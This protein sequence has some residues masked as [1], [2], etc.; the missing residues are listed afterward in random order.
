MAN[1]FQKSYYWLT[2]QKTTAKRS[3][4]VALRSNSSFS[5]SSDI[6]RLEQVFGI[7]LSGVSVN[8]HTALT[9]P[10]VLRCLEIR[11]D[12]PASMPLRV[13]STTASGPKLETGHPLDY[14]L[15]IRPNDGQ[16]PFIFRKT[17]G[18]H[19]DIWGV[20]VAVVNRDEYRNTK[21]F[22]ILQRGEYQIYETLDTPM[23]K[24]KRTYIENDGTAHNEE[25][26]IIWGGISTDGFH[27][28]GIVGCAT[29]VI[30][31]GLT[32]RQFINKYYE[33]G[34]FL[35][36]I[37]TSENNMSKDVAEQNKTNWQSAH[38]GSGQAGKVAVLSGG[39]KFQ[40]ITN[41]L[42]DSQLVEFLSLDKHEIYQAF[43]VPPHLVGDTTKQTSFGA[44]LESQ[45]TGFYTT[46]LRPLAIQLEQEIS[47]KCLKE[48]EQRKGKY[49]KHNFNALLRADMKTR[50]DSY[51]IG[52]QNGWLSANDI[53]GLEEM[54][55]Y[56]G[57]DTYMVNG[58]MIPV[59]QVGQ[60]Y[61]SDGNGTQDIALN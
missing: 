42:V 49:V 9:I 7:S 13:Y 6:A 1:F 47:Y 8:E 17:L 48:S 46:T 38:G 5:T 23:G 35:G 33:N 37:L 36:G 22:R 2:G 11:N 54:P 27:Y 45:T 24:Q 18:M 60:Q 32:T 31:T 61:N 16:T 55:H 59:A 4:G 51:A 50:Y 40:A 19:R 3:S 39:L 25:D 28:K 10:A 14:A 58:N 26:L 56:D 41:S 57:G 43:G 29:E 12:T 53:R 34:T 52:L 20:G 21:G 15:N 44:G 30:K